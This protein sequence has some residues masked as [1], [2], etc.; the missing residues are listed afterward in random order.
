MKLKGSI[1]SAIPEGELGILL[2]VI[3]SLSIPIGAICGKGAE[4]GAGIEIGRAGRI[5]D[6][7]EATEDAEARSSGGTPSVLMLLCESADTAGD[8]GVGQTCSLEAAP[9]CKQSVAYCSRASAKVWHYSNQRM[10]NNS[11]TCH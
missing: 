7:E 2:A 1:S 3:P 5:S 11:H 10:C 4:G 8:L 6:I 9:V